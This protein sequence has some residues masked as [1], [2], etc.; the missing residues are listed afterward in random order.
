MIRLPVGQ[1]WIVALQSLIAV[2]HRGG[3]VY[4]HRIGHGGFCV[5]IEIET[6][7]CRIALVLS[8]MYI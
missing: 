2:T 6:L 4:M 1:S 5:V 3:I 7:V 8:S